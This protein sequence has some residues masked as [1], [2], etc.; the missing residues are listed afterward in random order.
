MFEDELLDIVDEHDNVVE[1][2]L[3]SQAYREKLFPSIRAVWLMI[4]TVDGKFWI[5][6]RSSEKKVLPNHL[7][8]SVV[9]HVA[10]GESYEVAMCR[11]TMEEVNIDVECMPYKRLGKL[12]PREHDAFCM[13][14]VYELEVLK[15]FEVDYN[16]NDFSEGHWM[17][18]QEILEAIK[19]GEQ[20]KDMLPVVL[21]HFYNLS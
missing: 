1:Q 10:A 5:P 19:N 12:T 14:E 20:V 4:K 9:G 8:G 7:D 16:K 15:T 17:T 6:R 11:E 3:R 2:K 13:A 18:G 21:Q